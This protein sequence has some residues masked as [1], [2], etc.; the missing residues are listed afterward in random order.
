[1]NVKEKAQF[2]NYLKDQGLRWTPERERIVKEAFATQGHFEAE[3]L[4]Y[5]L[6]KKGSRISKASVY[7]TLPLLVKAG[8]IREVIYGEKHHHYEH[9]HGEKEHDHL[10]CLKCGQILEFQDDSL[11]E[12]ERQI[13]ERHHFRPERILVEIFGYCKRCQ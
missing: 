13:C 8:L 7:R 11:R 1:M 12:S 6:R 9:I 4:A 2:S 5:R 3:E 10:I